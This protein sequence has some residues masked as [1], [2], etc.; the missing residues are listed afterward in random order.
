MIPTL[1]PPRSCVPSRRRVGRRLGTRTFRRP[2]RRAAAAWGGAPPLAP[3]PPPTTHRFA[4]PS[5]PT[6]RPSRHDVAGA[7]PLQPT[8]SV[9]ASS[10][11]WVTAAPPAAALAPPP[12][13]QPYQPHAPRPRARR[14]RHARGRTAAAAPPPDGRAATRVGGAGA[15][16]RCAGTVC[17]G[18]AASPR[19]QRHRAPPRFPARE[20]ECRT[21][22]CGPEDGKYK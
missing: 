2:P 16:R 19:R 18:G 21:V 7:R 22:S 12:P 13:Y 8:P 10:A 1:Q 15:W 20:E 5:A 9:T 4:V 3:P 6:A 17:P 14:A 11:A